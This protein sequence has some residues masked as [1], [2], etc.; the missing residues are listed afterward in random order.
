M[1]SENNLIT[2]KTNLQKLRQTIKENRL[3]QLQ[4]ENR[5]IKKEL[6]ES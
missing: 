6:D 1:E 3:L 2:A 4:G 5:K